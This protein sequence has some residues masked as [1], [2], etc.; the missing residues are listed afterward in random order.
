M[1]VNFLIDSRYGGPQMILNHL[2]KKIKKKNKT[3]FFD[4]Q[5][6]NL[7]F[8]NLKKINKIFFI[9]DIFFNLLSLLINK[10]KFKKDKVFFIFSL[11]NIVPVILAIILKKKIVWYILEKPNTIFYIIFKILNF[12]SDIEV[13]CITDSLAKMLGLKKYQ[14]YFPT[15][16]YKYWIKKDKSK[17]KASNKLVKILCVGNLNKVKNHFQLIKYLEFSKLKYK[18]IIVGKKLETQKNYFFRLNKIIKNINSQN[19]NKI[20]IYQNKKSEFIRKILNDSDIF[21]LPSLEE[22]LSIALV[23]AMCSGTLCFVSKPSNHSKI[24]INKNNGFDFDL[25]KESF[26][27]TFRKINHLQ[28]NKREKIIKNAKQTVKKLILKNTIFEKKLINTLLLNHR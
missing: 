4:K 2:K 5:N 10:K 11:L 28:F 8:L 22:G 9:F 27:N 17:N 3:I 14:L 13:I 12:I 7:F 26:M 1:I 16:N 18:L 6:K 21:I 25:N 24:I 15:I 20:N 23:E 19:S